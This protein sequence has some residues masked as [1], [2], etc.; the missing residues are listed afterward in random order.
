MKACTPPSSLL[1]ASLA[2]LFVAHLGAQVVEQV[3][4]IKSSEC[5]QTSA[6]APFINPSPTGPNYG[7]PYNFSVDVSG[8]NI[9]GITPPQVTLPAGSLYP[10][11]SPT[12]HNGGVLVYNTNEQHW[13][14]GVNGNDYG[15]LTANDRDTAFAPGIYGLSVNGTSFNLNFP[16]TSFPANTPSVTLTGGAWARGVYMI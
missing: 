6:A 4:V 10:T 12:Q 1:A 14:Y 2:L 16:T 13:A 3:T 5:V 8:T 7:G 11:Q 15:G 9:S